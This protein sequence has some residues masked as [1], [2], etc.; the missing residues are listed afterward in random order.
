M[1]L[2]SSAERWAPAHDAP[3]E[4]HHDHDEPGPTPFAGVIMWFT[5]LLPYVG[6]AALAY[7]TYTLPSGWMLLTLFLLSYLAVGFGV[8][9]GYHRLLAHKSFESYP[10]VEGTFY[11]LGCMA[12]QGPPIRWTATH[13]RHH[14]RSDHDGDPHSPHLHGNGVYGVVRGLW[15]AHTGWLLT[16]DKERTDRSVKDLIR[17]PMI[18]RIDRLYWLWLTISVVVPIALGLAIMHTW[19]GG[20]ICLFW[21]TI[22]RISLMHH[23]T[24]S[25]NS[26]CHFFGLP[27][28]PQRR[29]QSQQPDRGD[30]QP[31]RGLAQQP[32]RLPDQRPPRPAVVGVRQQLGRDPHAATAAPGVGRPPAERERPSTESERRRPRVAGGPARRSLWSNWPHFQFTA[33]MLDARCRIGKLGER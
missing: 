32:P 13:R 29:P 27:E 26:I 6:I 1:D 23:A 10:W 11:A 15:H 14:Q 4:A 17:N 9:I 25:V 7:W 20:L 33:I 2:W 31:R 24:W 21:M 18:R 16:A 3:A 8:T 22:I 28:L 12:M 19:T 30:H 5:V